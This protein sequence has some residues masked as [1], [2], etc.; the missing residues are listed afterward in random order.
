MGGGKIWRGACGA[1]E[2]FYG[3]IFDIVWWIVGYL[4]ILWA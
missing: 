4:H 3:K 2:Q 1:V